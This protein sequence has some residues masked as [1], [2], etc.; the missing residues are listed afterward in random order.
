MSQATNNSTKW[1]VPQ[2]DISITT[3][4]TST[5]QKITLATAGTYVDKDIEISAPTATVAAATVTASS[6]TITPSV[7]STAN[8]DGS[9]N[10]TG[11]GTSSINVGTAGYVSSSV[12]TKNSG[13]PKVSG[14]VAG[15]TL[16]ATEVTPAASAQTVTIGAGYYPT[17]RTV[18]VKAASAGTAAG[19]TAS[20]TDPGNTYTSKS[21]TLA[22]G[23]YLKIDAGYVGNT[24]ISLADL[25]P[26]DAN[27]PAAESS[28][29]I[30]NGYSAYDKDG[31]LIT[32]GINNG[33]VTGADD[34]N[35]LHRGDTLTVGAGYYGSALTYSVDVPDAQN[36][37]VNSGQ[38]I[39]VSG[40]GTPT[41]DSS[42]TSKYNIA[43]SGSSTITGSVGTAGWATSVTGATVTASGNATVSKATI[44]N[45]ATLPTG[46]TATTVNRGAYLKVGTGYNPSD[47]YYLAQANSGNKE[48][49]AQTGTS[50]DGY[51]TAS[52]KS[53][54]ASVTATTIPLT[55][56]GPT[57]NNGK[58]EITASGSQTVNG[59]ATAGWVSSVTGATVSASTTVG[60]TDNT[61][62]LDVAELTHAN[63]ATQTNAATVELSGTRT[64]V[65]SATSGNYYVTITG[66]Q[67]AAG[68]VT[69][70][71]SV[72]TGYVPSDGLSSNATIATS[73]SV[74]NSGTK[75]YLASTAITGSENVTISNTTDY[76]LSGVLT[77]AP[78]SGVYLT[79]TGNGSATSGSVYNGSATAAN[80][81]I[82]VFDGT[83]TVA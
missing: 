14:T 22:S 59:K 43:V 51:A 73:A 45:G 13:T 10:I 31:A 37:K 53:G 80:K 19:I 83:Y 5:G 8:T 12:G 3:S 77:T 2:S 20:A 66:S 47:V 52:V 68:S 38:T 17:S 63:T 48:L 35:E 15:S 27:I 25:V 41:V 29:Y 46:T 44:T 67:K 26:D 23:G 70:A 34:D 74:T 4:G 7:S 21:V 1:T 33:T 11:S 39:T 58:Y 81:Y 76:T 30:L 62:R 75:I 56:S 64:G 55:I 32:G 71:A 60:T 42:D 57:L 49:T 24:K 72:S 79:L 18:T 54:S 40:S 82:K 50:V 69:H 9:Y 6:P 36:V 28:P 78:T 65:N 16:S 61:L